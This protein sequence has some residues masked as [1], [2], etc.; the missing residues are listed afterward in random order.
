MAAYRDAPTGDRLHLLVRWLTCPFPPVVEA[1]PAV[2]RVLEVGCGHGLLSSYLAAR[3][4]GVTVHGVDIDVDKIEVARASV[5]AGET[6]LSFGASPSGA[7]PEGPWDGIVLVDVLYLLDEQGQRALLVE[8]ASRLAPGGRLVVKEMAT[9][10]RW[11]AR[12]NAL[13][14]SVSVRVLGITEGSRDFAF[15]DPDV[16]ARWLVEA[17]LTDVRAR[18]LDRGRAHP[19]HL[20]A[21]RAPA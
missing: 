21:A 3:R 1:L 19:H 12:L 6:R 8:C 14:E 2:G 11:K 17:G 15:V 13:Q 18:R 5:P 16:R 10:P 20:L 9:R 4:P 7:V